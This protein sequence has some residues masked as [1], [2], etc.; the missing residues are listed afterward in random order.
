MTLYFSRA[1]WGSKNITPGGSAVGRQ[2]EIVAHHAWRPHIDADAT[3]DEECR[4][5]RGIQD[6]HLGKEWAD[7]GYS[8]LQFQSG[9][10]Y[11]GRGWFR[12]GAHT[13]G[14][15]HLPSICFVIDGDEH[16][17][18]EWAWASARALI[19]DGVRRG[20]LTPDYTVSGHT[21]RAA[22]S[23]PGRRTYP[24]IRARLG[25]Q[26]KEP[27]VA[28]R[29]LAQAVVYVPGSD[30]DEALAVCAGAYYDAATVRVEDGRLV[31]DKYGPC[32]VGFG[33]LVGKAQNKDLVDRSLFADGVNLI[34]GATG[35][36]TAR[37]LARTFRD[38][39]HD[40]I[41]RRGKPW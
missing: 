36:D 2:N 3:F 7:I 34:A 20:A 30:W 22:K 38:H 17:P 28:R 25:P 8:F 10:A 31:S 41:A 5:V 33:W 16:E 26:V 27:T 18:T 4:I 32:E 9:R 19:A 29:H 1:A 21:D 11:E 37:D 15:N 13:A 23:C 6:F 35:H 12:T 39:P 40:S 24:L 14:A